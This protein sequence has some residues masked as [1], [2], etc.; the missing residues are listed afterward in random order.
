MALG[1]D[2]VVKLY[3]TVVQ[4]SF[5]LLNRGRAEGESLT[6]VTYW[7]VSMALACHSSEKR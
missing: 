1:D 3:I 7:S 2:E 4:Y 6:K 5:D